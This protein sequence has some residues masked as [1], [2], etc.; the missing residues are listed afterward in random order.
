MFPIRRKKKKRSKYDSGDKPE[1]TIRKI[2]ST[3]LFRFNSAFYHA[4][5][6]NGPT[7]IQFYIHDGRM[8][9]RFESDGEYILRPTQVNFVYG[10]SAAELMRQAERLFGKIKPNEMKHM[11]VENVN[12]ANGVYWEIKSV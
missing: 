1:V 7:N 8:L 10:F 12:V 11:R 3:N 4:A 6:L 2:G 5:E 9:F